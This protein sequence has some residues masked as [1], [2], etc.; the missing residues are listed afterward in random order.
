MKVTLKRMGN[1]HNNIIHSNERYSSNHGLTNY[2]EH[3]LSL[4]FDKE[5]QVRMHAVNTMNLIIRHGLVH[6]LQ[7]AISTYSIHITF[8]LRPYQI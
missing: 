8:I 1:C 2:F 4:L 7:V 6:P 5:V 3:V